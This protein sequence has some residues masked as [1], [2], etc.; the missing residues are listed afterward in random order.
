MPPLSYSLYRAASHLAA[1]LLRRLLAKRVGRGK[2]IAERLPERFGIDATPRPDGKLLWL[3]AASVGETMSVL[4]VLSA[5]PASLGVLVTTGTVTSA[6]L[7]AQRLPNLGLSKR[8]VHRFVPLDVPEWVERF[9]DHWRPDAGALVESE[10][11]P[12]LILA[13]R[14]RHIPMALLNARLSAGSARGWG[15]VPGF[16]R[17]VLQSFAIIAAQSEQDAARLRALGASAATAPGN[18]KFA[19]SPLPASGPEL[20]RLREAIGHR[21]IFLAASTHDGE[22]AAAIAAHRIVAA[23]CP[24]LLNIIAPRHPERGAAIATLAGDAPRRSRGELP[25]DGPFWIADTLGEMGLFYRLA[26][27]AFI[28]G[29]IASRGGQNP[30]E[31]AR[32]GC[33]VSCGPHMENQAEAASLLEDGGAL[34]RVADAASLAAWIGAMLTDAPARQRASEAGMQAASRDADLPRQFA[35]SLAV[36]AGVPPA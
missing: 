2:E 34:T 22:E 4:P 9:L 17:Y 18:L 14:A 28:G 24:N 7:L 23:Q 10:L 8:V 1:P 15:R 13:A 21:P 35:A 6:Q 27:L 12:N 11:W 19:A 32:L 16:A 5:L 20:A 29:S 3:H 31:A 25:G 36:M 33:V 26:P 30:L